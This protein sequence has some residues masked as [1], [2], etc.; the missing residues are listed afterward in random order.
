MKNYT[1][2]LECADKTFY[3]GWTNNIEKR[4]EAHN[5]GSGSKYTR[6]RR[7][8][9]LVYLEESATKEEAMSREWEIKRLTRKEKQ[10]LIQKGQDPAKNI[11]D[12]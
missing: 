11:N 2:I 1:Y 4:L 8:V 12:R 9:R 7:P 3:C 6:A 5:N 10:D